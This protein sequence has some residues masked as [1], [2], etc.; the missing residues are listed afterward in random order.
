MAAHALELI[1]ADDSFTQN[2]REVLW[3][4]GV[5]EG[6]GTAIT[7]ETVAAIPT[8]QYWEIGQPRPIHGDPARV[9]THLHS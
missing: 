2:G 5:G 1:E 9:L 3:G 8:R 4:G 7:A 6:R